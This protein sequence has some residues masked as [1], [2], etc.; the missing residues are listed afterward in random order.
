MPN[1]LPRRVDWFAA[2]ALALGFASLAH[3]A[4]PALSGGYNQAL[5]LKVDGTVWHTGSSGTCTRPN[6]CKH[7]S[8][9]RLPDLA[10]VI[11]IAAANHANLFLKENGTVWS[12][13]F[14]LDGVLGG[15][16]DMSESHTSTRQVVSLTQ[17]TQID[18][19][20][21]HC[22]ALRSDGFVWAWG[23]NGNGQIG[24]GTSE[25][26]RST[27]VR[28]DGPS[29][30]VAISAADGNR[31]LALAADGT[32]WTWGKFLDTR[33][34]TPQK[35]VGLSGVRAMAGS[36]QL[37]LF[38][39]T[40]GTVWTQGFAGAIVQVAGILDVVA[41]AAAAS[42]HFALKRDGTV[43][44]W[45][46]NTGG[47]IGSGDFTRTVYDTPT[48]V[49]GLAN[50][51][52]VGISAGGRS[53]YA[54]AAD[55]TAYAW[56]ANDFGQLGDNTLSDRAAAVRMAGPGGVG[57]FNA[58]A[59]QPVTNQVPNAGLF[60]SPDSGTAPL[61]VSAEARF[62]FDTDGTIDRQE[63]FVSDGQT[64][65]GPTARFVFSHAGSFTISLLVTDN[66]GGS[67]YATQAIV[68]ASAT[69]P[70][71]TKA[72]IA[73][74]RTAAA[75][76][77]ADG[78]A[79]SWGTN[80]HLGRGERP[81]GPGNGPFQT[82]LEGPIDNIAGVTS[83]AMGSGGGL[84]SMTDGS[85]AAWGANSF[86]QV[87]DGTVITRL[88]PVPVQGIA[89][90]IAVAAGEEHSLALKSDGTVWSWGGNTNG[91]L[92]T[93]TA[94]DS[95]I[96]VQVRD[97]ANV[98]A[99]AAGARSSAALKTD[100]SVWAWG[101]NQ[102]GELGITPGPGRNTAAPISSLSRI[103]RIWC[104]PSHCF[105][106]DLD[107]VVWG[108]GANYLGQLGAGHT[109]S[110]SLPAAIPAYR[111]FIEFAF[112]V[113]HSI[114]LRADGSVWRSGQQRASGPPAD[115]ALNALLPVAIPGVRNAIGIGATWRG[116][117]AFALNPDGTVLAWGTNASGEV[118]DGT[119][120]V[121]ASPVSMSNDTL[122]GLFD[123]IPDV[124][125]DPSLSRPAPFFSQAAS[126]GSLTDPTV[127]VTNLTR[128]NAADVGTSASVFVFAL[129]PA[130]LVNTSLGAK[131]GQVQCVLAQ[132]NA[133]GQL[134]AVSASSLQA[135]V[136]GVL[137]AQGQAVTVLN[138]VPTATI[139]GATFFVGYGT[140]A[141][142]MVTSGTN[143]AV[144][145][146]PGATGDVACQPQPPQTGWWWN[147]AEGGRG[148]SIEAAG[149][150]IFFASYLYDVSGR[151]TW[152]VASGNTSFDGSL[153]TGNL[154]A[155]SQGQSLTSAYK[156]P[157]PVTNAG[158]ITLAFNDANHGTMIWPGGTVAIERFNIVPSG[159]T[160]PAQ[161]NQPE[162]GWWWNPAESGRGFFLE[163]QGGE[164][165]MAGYMYDDAGNPIWYLSSNTTPST[166]LQ[167]YQNTWWQYA[168]GQTL[169][170]A[171]KPAAQ[172]NNNV[173]PV[174][175]T[176]QGSENALMTLPGGRVTA[177]R[178]F[179]F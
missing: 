58:L 33:L 35:I 94:P 110:P 125:N 72:T 38:L 4:T 86:G 145:S 1:H 138:G 167:S 140:S 75:A 37:S 25:F 178:R 121:R 51:V 17:I 16:T 179:R 116:G 87:G 127:T 112:G 84:A 153:F 100:G 71:Q 82:T 67:A 156:A 93:G 45:G 164:I 63:W 46:L 54:L 155:Y 132:L 176:F 139:D 171:F 47:V 48:R 103:N 2:T 118:G 69:G 68:V 11:D 19:V 135:Y 85:V 113:E 90:V 77:R 74:G 18:C 177:L 29:S 129:A 3:A 166:N 163:W 39:K 134:Q 13:G 5:V 43:W 73:G 122:D 170:G 173:G 148:Y 115:P 23:S 152:L 22:L 126:T 168:N 79:F 61:T 147:A 149:N 91:Q 102:S 57:S 20:G 31:S 95:R 123:L 49:Q 70:I 66:L 146:V 36:S 174:S 114:G 99:I 141:S 76:I 56:G 41:I 128:F 151:A 32:V 133:S 107:G 105:A 59:D 28:V 44:A 7:T 80:N 119:L 53:A 162:G 143:R 165:F 97:L 136:T 50:A 96:P 40:D 14:N 108:W 88:S 169:T 60:V 158:A 52:V 78:K 117:G 34:S 144:V 120:A 98:K 154:E 62:V 42:Q 111:G 130:S 26:F 81:G 64:A 175:I 159:L 104:G 24:D 12:M 89:S 161:S 157:G 27:P 15:G 10:G 65:T 92:G 8:F 106:A 109:I 30:V 172:V 55:G 101:T 160:L 21:T 131:A 6:V 83:I 150:H 124:A 142:S 137:S 9:E